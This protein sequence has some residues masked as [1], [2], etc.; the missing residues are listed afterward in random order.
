MM[1]EPEQAYSI[2][3]KIYSADPN[4]RDIAKKVKS[5]KGAAKKADSGDKKG[6]DSPKEGKTKD[7]ISY[8]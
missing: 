8:V 5:L 3:E 2:Y 4:F 6:G 1:N 7:K